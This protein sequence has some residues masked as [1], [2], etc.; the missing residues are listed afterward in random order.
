MA[1]RPR[2]Q[3]IKTYNA[4]ADKTLQNQ[5]FKNEQLRDGRYINEYSNLTHVFFDYCKF[6]ISNSTTSTEVANN[7]LDY[8]IVNT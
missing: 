1:I 4:E 3:Y 8:I 7:S 5:D 6:C 2:A